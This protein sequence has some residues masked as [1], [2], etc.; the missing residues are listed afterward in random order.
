M[1]IYV[2]PINFPLQFASRNTLYSS[3][4]KPSVTFYFLWLCFCGLRIPGWDLM[5]F[6]CVT[7]AQTSEEI[8]KL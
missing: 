5:W 6:S 3:V 7:L 2:A 8:A 4:F 1:Y